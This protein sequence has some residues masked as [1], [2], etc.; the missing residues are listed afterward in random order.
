MGVIGR[1]PPGQCRADILTKED[2]HPLSPQVAQWNLWCQHSE[3]FRLAGIRANIAEAT[4]QLH[5]PQQLREDAP[6]TL[7]QLPLRAWGPGCS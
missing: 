1:C 7:A 3:R 4:R 6:L 2:L 5:T